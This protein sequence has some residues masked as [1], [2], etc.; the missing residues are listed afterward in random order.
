MVYKSVYTEVEVDVDLEEFDTDDLLEELESRGSLPPEGN[1]DAK[2]LIEQ[3]YYLRRQGQAYEHLLD[4]LIYSV[5]G[6]IAWLNLNGLFMVQWPGWWL[7]MHG[8][9]SAPALKNFK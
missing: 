3:M 7:R 1:V 9:L 2:E 6:R 5:L 4:P 8:H